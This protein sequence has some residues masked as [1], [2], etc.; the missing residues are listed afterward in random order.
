ME[1]LNL[2]QEDKGCASIV[3]KVVPDILSSNKISNFKGLDG[4]I[5]QTNEAMDKSL[6][7]LP[8]IFDN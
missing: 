7:D 2:N 1:A 8:G 5:D 3:S 6:F 4:A